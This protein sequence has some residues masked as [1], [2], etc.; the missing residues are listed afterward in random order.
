MITLR[1]PATKILIVLALTAFALSA[2]ADGYTQATISKNQHAL[3]IF[4]GA[5]KIMAPRTDSE[6]RAFSNAQISSNGQMVG[7]LVLSSSCCQSYPIPLSL[8]IFRDGKVIR[9]FEDERPVW[10]WSFQNQDTAVAYLLRTTHGN[11]TVSYKL[12][13]IS[14]GKLI[15]E[16]EC[17]S[18][19]EAVPESEK[20]APVPEWVW[21]I[22]SECPTHQTEANT[23]SAQPSGNQDAAAVT[24]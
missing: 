13:R 3:A 24:R 21:S 23:S 17:F 7:W 8:V 19:P 1:Y 12:R 9:K 22:A 16:F 20:N 6:Q 14:D 4:S 10:N 2:L 11:S 15:E 18:D 5:H